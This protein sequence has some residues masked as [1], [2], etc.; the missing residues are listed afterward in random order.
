[1]FSL[2][3]NIVITTFLLLSTLSFGE[4]KELLGRTELWKYS[5]KG[6]ISENW[7]QK[8]FNDVEWKLGK[9][10]LGYGDDFSETDPT[11][12]IGTNIEFGKAEEKYTTSYFRK[13]INITN[14]NDIK[15]LEVFLHVDDGAVIYI[16]GVEA[17]RR[18]ITDEVVTFNSL[19]KFKAKEETFVIPKTLLVSGKNIIS[20]EVHQ[21]GPNSSDL[22]FELGIKAILNDGIKN[23]SQTFITQEVKPKEI[24]L[25]SKKISKITI[26]FTGDTQTTK[27][28]TWYT[29]LDSKKSDLQIVEK[30]E[31]TPDFSKA[32]K[33]R[34]TTTI[35]TNTSKEYLHKVE[36][37]NLESGKTYYFRVGDEKLNL[38]SEIGSFST[39]KKTGKFS[40]IDYADTQ[41]KSEDEAILSGETLKK[42]FETVK[43]AEFVLHNGDIVDTGMNEL[44]W[45][46][47]IGHSQN[48]LLN[49]TIA[50]VAG[51]HEEEKDS[52]IE[53]FNIKEAI[54]S[55]TTTGAYYSYDY[56]N[57]HF[58]MLN[59]NEDSKEFNNFSIEQI[60]WLKKDAISAKKR[61]IKWIITTIH[62]G[63]YTTSNHATDIDI[64]GAYGVRT[65]V[66]TLFDD[67][68]VD[69]VFQGHD[70]IYARTKVIKDG[71]SEK[72][73]KVTE[74]ING[75]KVDFEKNP[76]GTIYMIPSTGGPK[77]YYKN[78]KIDASYYD[79]FEKANEHSAAK[80][81]ND[82]KDSSRPLR[83]SIQN[84]AGI[85]IDNN[86]LT[87]TVYEIDQKTD[88][89]PY[90]IDQFGIIKK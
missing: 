11:I 49:T 34:G 13:D 44:Q 66:A 9:A 17:F 68:G 1:M 80:Y 74:I 21:D 35:P 27:G 38:W 60:E 26:T 65:K 16:N 31:N 90:I 62:K 29:S 45:D 20:A 39:S 14:F 55:D 42:A 47:L 6:Q 5:D 71:K 56:D 83:G 28:F 59:S 61:G 40:F 36:A 12:A 75:N 52:F 87:V 53:H 10:P 89:S 8:D 48:S 84:F 18:G 86:K 73:N 77:V 88:K 2:R 54:G 22:W 30:K 7:K 41:A 15:E 3:K 70:H 63:P 19:G 24:P 37:T 79:L 64:I 23:E 69:L 81:G 85:N 82:P 4:T 51:N 33:F 50:P 46:W 57:T 67:I 72:S 78:K 25:E 76:N 32:I 43:N 58:I